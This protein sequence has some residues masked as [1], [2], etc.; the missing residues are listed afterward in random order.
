MGG[1]LHV[2]AVFTYWVMTGYISAYTAK[3]KNAVINGLVFS[4]NG[5]LNVTKSHIEKVYSLEY[6]D[7]SKVLFM[8]HYRR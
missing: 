4:S 5:Q 6:S 8:T 3:C 2:P 1:Q 7:V